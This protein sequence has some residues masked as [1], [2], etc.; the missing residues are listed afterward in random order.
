MKALYIQYSKNTTHLLNFTK[1]IL[2]KS[3]FPWINV[4]QTTF[5]TSIGFS[6]SWDYE[7]NKLLPTRGPCPVFA[8]VVCIT[9]IN[10][11]FKCREINEGVKEQ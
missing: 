8:A 10:R 4:V 11:R 7:G 6:L 1:K 5:V 2:K 3:T 9:D